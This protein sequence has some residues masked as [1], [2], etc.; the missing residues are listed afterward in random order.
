MTTKLQKKLTNFFSKISLSKPS[1]NEPES[2][3]PTDN[4]TPSSS[5]SSTSFHLELTSSQLSPP[6]SQS[7]QQSIES[8]PSTQT[9]TNKPRPKSSITITKINLATNSVATQI[10]QPHL[11]PKSS[12]QL[13]SSHSQP[14]I[15]YEQD[16]VT[17]P[18]LYVP[19]MLPIQPDLS[20]YDAGPHGTFK[21]IW[22]KSFPWLEYSRSKKAAFCFV[23]RYFG[24]TSSKSQE[25][26]TQIGFTNFKKGPEKFKK[27]AETEVHKTAKQLQA[28]RQ[29]TLKN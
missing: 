11:P 2:G 15:C 18:K 9:I 20:K 17:S 22:Y 7:S 26:F 28:N 27:H 21:A 12:S 29:M 19:G 8:S 6:S 5:Q 23:C 16:P 25:A 14:F 1:Q 24:E 10:N 4:I 3:E 13:N